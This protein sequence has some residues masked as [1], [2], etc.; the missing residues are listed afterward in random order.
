MQLQWFE[1]SR[2]VSALSL[3]LVVLY[4]FFVVIVMLNVLFAVV[5]DS[6]DYAMKRAQQLFLRSRLEC[7]AELDSLGLTHEV[8]TSA[9]MRR[10]EELLRPLFR[11]LEAPRSWLRIKA[12]KGDEE[13]W[14]GRVKHM[15][16]KIEEVSVKQEASTKREREVSEQSAQQRAKELE[17]RMDDM[18]AQTAKRI[19]DMQVQTAKHMDDMQAQNAK[20]MDDIMAAIQQ[21]FKLENRK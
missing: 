12:D 16:R 4:L 14:L 8:P 7:V 10:A 18:Q 19:E 2:S 1:G 5:S 13:N 15:E 6:Y 11:L 20:R 17:K 21:G 3:F 9:V